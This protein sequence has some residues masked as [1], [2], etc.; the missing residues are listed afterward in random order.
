MTVKPENGFHTADGM[1]F[2]QCRS[3]NFDSIWILAWNTD[4]VSDSKEWNSASGET[5]PASTALHEFPL[6][7]TKDCQFDNITITDDTVSC[8]DDNLQCWW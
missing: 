4:N 7:E 3:L 6:L 2:D 8:H 1:H 5:V